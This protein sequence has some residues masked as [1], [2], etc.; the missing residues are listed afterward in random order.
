MT[1]RA[2]IGDCSR[3]SQSLRVYLF[4]FVCFCY[5]RLYLAFEI[6]LADVVKTNH[7]SITPLTEQKLMI[8]IA[9]KSSCPEISLRRRETPHRHSF[10]KHAQSSKSRLSDSVKQCENYRK[11]VRE[12]LK[13]VPQYAI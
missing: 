8:D 9:M 6:Y 10:Q 4:V 5:S 2:L 3:L 11:G 13:A 7:A 1:D 12:T